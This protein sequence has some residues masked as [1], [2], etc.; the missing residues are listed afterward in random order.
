MV[1]C[2][3]IHSLHVLGKR[4]RPWEYQE[5]VSAHCYPQYVITLLSITFVVEKKMN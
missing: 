4:K 2:T 1:Q 5:Q 3:W